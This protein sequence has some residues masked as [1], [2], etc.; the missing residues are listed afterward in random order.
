[1]PNT[2]NEGMKCHMCGKDAEEFCRDCWQPVCEDCCVPFTFQNQIDF[3]LCLNC[4]DGIQAQRAE[5]Y[6]QQEKAAQRK[7]DMRC[8]KNAASRARYRS[9]ENKAKRRAKREALLQS[10]RESSRKLLESIGG[11]LSN[12]GIK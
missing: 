4:N 10:R 6:S 5:H 1:M 8:K 9:P 11:I 7:N 12:M 2:E 3:A